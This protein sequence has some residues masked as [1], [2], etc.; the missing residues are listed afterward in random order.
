MILQ[1]ITFPVDHICPEPQM[2]FHG[3]DDEQITETEVRVKKGQTLYLD[4]YFNS[5]SLGKWMKYTQIKDL[6][7]TLD[8]DGEYDIRF[9]QLNGAQ[10]IKANPGDNTKVVY[11]Y[12]RG[13]ITNLSC[14]FASDY[15]PVSEIGVGDAVENVI[16]PVIRAKTDLVLRGGAYETSDEA[17]NDVKFALCICTFKREEA[18]KYNVNAVINGILNNPDSELKDAVEVFVSDNGQTIPVDEFDS[19]KVHVYPNK[20]LGGAGGF[21]RAMIESVLRGNESNF[22]HVILMDDDIALDSRVLEKNYNFLCFLKPEHNKKMIGG[23]LFHLKWRYMQFEA[24]ARFAGTVIQSYNQ[25]WD[26]RKPYAVAANEIENPMNFN[27]WWYCCIP[28]NYVREDNLPI[29]VF[30]HRDD[31]EY[32]MRN[33][34]NGTILLNGICVWHPQGPN[35]APTLMNYYDVRNDLIAM[36]DSPTRAT[37]EEFLNQIF[38]G[39][40]GNILR[41]RYKV[42]DCIFYAI[43]DFYK[44][45]DYFINMD[46]VANHKELARFNYEFKEPEAYNIDLSTI[47]DERAEHFKGHIFLRAAIATW[48]MPAHNKTRVCTMN[49]IGV[50]FRAKRI[51][52][53]DEDRNAGMLTEKSYKEAFRLFF[54]YLKI[55]KMILKHHDE[56]MKTWSD[57]KKDYTS[58]AFWEK[59][60]EI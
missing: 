58:L 47:K 18:L 22:T 5:F 38:R 42:I 50:G 3:V 44:G 33:Q 39:C 29:P 32:G 21:T 20:N 23:E 31:V 52:T 28:L 1:K 9:Y 59:Y 19:D 17:V 2:Y 36:C 25:Q 37:A 4:T 56:M 6:K 40:L 16:C 45:P 55:R 15:M 51:Y 48:L 26:M 49:D 53:Y 43:E 13:K 8:I 10:V 46:T 30:I 54:H 60:L 57:R 7:L 24:G 41:Y 27:G 34:A 14:N 11:Q 12:G 35:K